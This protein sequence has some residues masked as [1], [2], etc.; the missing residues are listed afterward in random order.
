MQPSVRSRDSRTDG[1][2]T[3][4]PWPVTFSGIWPG[5]D[6]DHITSAKKLSIAISAVSWLDESSGSGLPFA[7][8]MPT[9]NDDG[10]SHAYSLINFKFYSYFRSFVR[11]IASFS[12]LICP[13]NIGSLDPTPSYLLFFA[14]PVFINSAYGIIYVVA[15]KQ[16][17][18][19]LIFECIWKNHESVEIRVKTLEFLC[20]YVCDNKP[21]A[22]LDYAA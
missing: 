15:C 5:I 17:N 11:F 14:L 16:R 19:Q 8:I 12:K 9:A 10:V 6:L 2:G 20:A 22:R 18:E 4:W 1:T 3:E 7:E 13:I 21:S